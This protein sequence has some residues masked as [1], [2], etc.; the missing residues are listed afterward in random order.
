MPSGLF[1]S[2]S[3][4]K[5]FVVGERTRAVS[6][7]VKA[8]KPDETVAGWV[9]QEVQRSRYCGVVLLSD[10]GIFDLALAG[11]WNYSGRL[12]GDCPALR[13]LVHGVHL[14]SLSL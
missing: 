11:L 3:V 6:V 5:S 9:N 10:G 14:V 13:M 7:G 1:E 2:L 12:Q 8:P 4:G